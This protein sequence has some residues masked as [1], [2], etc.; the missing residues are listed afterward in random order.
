VFKKIIPAYYWIDAKGVIGIIALNAKC[1]SK[2]FILILLKG[3]ITLKIERVARLRAG[4]AG[5]D[6]NVT[7][8]I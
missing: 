6:A 3:Y 7:S 2:G 1:Q 4:S 8:F 5:G